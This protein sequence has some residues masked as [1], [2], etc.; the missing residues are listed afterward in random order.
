MQRRSF[1]QTSAAIGAGSLASPR[2][3]SAQGQNVLRFVPQADIAILDPIATTGFVTR[4]HGFLVFDTLYGW[5]EQYRA[6]PQMVEG[7]VVED[8]G[9]TWLMTLR[10]GL[11]FH[12]GEPVR[13]RDVVASLRR[14]GARDSFGIAALAA[15][16]EITAPSDRVVRWRFKRPFPLLPDALGKIGANVA[17]IMPE[18][19]ANA[20]PA[21]PISEMVGS[22][23][24]RFAASERVPGS[25]AVY[26]KFDGYVP[27]SGGT[28]SLLAGPKVVNID[29][30]EWITIPDASTASA[31]LQQREIDWWEQP[32]SDLLPLLRRGRGIKIEVLDPTGAI[33]MLRFN[34]LQPPFDNPAIRRAV[35]GAI[36]QEDVMTA[37]AGTDRSL[38]KTGVGFFAPG[39]VMASDVGMEALTGARDLAASRRALEQAG[40]KGEKVLMM[41]VTDFPAITAMSEVVADTFRRIGI[42]VDYAAMD[43]ASALRRQANRDTPDRGGYNAFCTYTAGVNQFNPAAHN[44]IRGSGLSATFGWSTSARLEELRNEWLQSTTDEER[45]RIG[46]DMQRQAFIDVPYVPLG[47]FYQPTAYRDD[48]QGVLKGLP[49]FWNVKRG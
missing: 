37:V 22:G 36:N 16:D 43:W 10:E 32:T 28:T 24:F 30:V 15:T 18:R 41:G 39:S 11:R 14:W 6:H 3:A 48:L 26:T 19:L 44:F 9:L 42:N 35:L 29:R 20:D 45:A 23:P 5:D 47:Q 12:D 31:A 40:Y 33:A 4:N 34:H 17:F 21:L 2:L 7:H 25:R 8:N 27:R 38:W 49:L 46:R 1:L 13:A